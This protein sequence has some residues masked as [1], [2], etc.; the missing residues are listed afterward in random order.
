[1]LYILLPNLSLQ[2]AVQGFFF[3]VSIST[4]FELA[5]VVLIGMMGKARPPAAD[6]IPYEPGE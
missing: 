2:N 3:D 5:I 6:G 4:K 1:M